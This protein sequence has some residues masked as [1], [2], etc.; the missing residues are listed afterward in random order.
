MSALS[1][2]HEPGILLV[3]AKPTSPR[4]LLEFHDWYDTEHG[5]ARLKL[6]DEYFSHGYRYKSRDKDTVWLAAYEMKRLSAAA[7][8]AYTKMRE[9][10]SHREQEIFRHKLMVLSRQFLLLDTVSG[11]STGRSAELC[12]TSFYVENKAARAVSSWYCK[13]STSDPS[14]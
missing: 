3:L 9:N 4:Y 2:C 1:Q 7:D 12:C 14:S 5:P 11:A 6:G 10:R 13:V 8:P